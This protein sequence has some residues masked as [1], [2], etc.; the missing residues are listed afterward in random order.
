MPAS[1]ALFWV[2]LLAVVVGS[3]VFTFFP[4]YRPGIV[5][6]WLDT[7]A[8]FTPAETP[9]QA[10]EKFKECI[11]KRN[12]K[13]AVKYVA[14]DYK[15]EWSRA[16]APATKLA[17]A[18][19]DLYYNVNDVVHLNSPDANYVL[20]ALQPFPKDFEFAVEKPIN[21]KQYRVL[22]QLFPTEFPYDQMKM[23]SD[24]VALATIKF[25][26]APAGQPK[27]GRMNM[28]SF[29]P[30]IFLSLVPIGV[31]WDGIVALKEEGNEKEKGWKIYFPLT[32]DIPPK[33]DYLTHNYGNYVQALKNVK[34]AIKH[35]AASKNEFES[36]LSKYL[37]ESK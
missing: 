31:A 23:L 9:Q 15:Q 19:D 21:D 26:L 4:E 5:Q 24:K 13:T 18:V 20:D 34:Y 22:S 16:A 12:Y 14:G 33:V 25:K 2:I 10:L 35:D 8:G 27:S 7:A 36:E 28:S 37:L 6:G 11:N 17:D 1:K 3:I 32:T 29:E 30:K